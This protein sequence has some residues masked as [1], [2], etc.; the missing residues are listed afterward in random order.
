M[1]YEAKAHDVQMIILKEL[2]LVAGASY[3][4]I[5][6]QTQL[7]SDHFNFHIKAL[8]KNGYIT[9]KDQSYS[10]TAKGKEYANRMDTDDKTIEKQPKL[11]VVLIIENEKGQFLTQ[12]RLK[13]PFYGYW[14]RP[15]GKIRWGET[16]LEAA[17]REL[18][19]ESGLEA[20]LRLSGFYHKM[21]YAE[22]TKEI[23]EDKLFV[24]IY[25]NNPK[26]DLIEEAEGCRN[27]WMSL[28]EVDKLD[29][30]FDLINEL[31]VIAKNPDISFIEKQYFYN[32]D[33]Y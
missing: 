5:L 28:H 31:T 8:I 10:L 7:S 18:M 3:S 11:S 15:T 33:Q 30:K 6:K 29:K 22:D 12:Q 27:A 23:L 26:N 16:F 25:G 9:K 2:L 17:A 4:E 24:L 14:A 1:T 19:E 13:Q 32:N 20:E 21:D